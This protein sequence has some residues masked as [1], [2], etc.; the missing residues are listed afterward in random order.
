MGIGVLIDFVPVHFATNGDGLARLDGTYLYEYDSDVGHSEWGTCN[1]NFYRGE[2]R[3]FLNSAC[4]M[5]MDVY[6]CDGIRMDAISRAIYWQGDPA[7]GV[8]E[9]ALNFLRALN[10]G[11]NERWPTG[12][13]VAEDSTYYIK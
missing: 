5:W 2:V 9:G 10:H 8:N 11:L 3:T 12:I 1:F 6:H 7:R 4:A 13:Y